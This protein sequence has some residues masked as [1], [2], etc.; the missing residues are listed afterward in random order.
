M[1]VINQVK[2]LNPEVRVAVGGSVEFDNKDSQPHT[3]TS[4]NGSFDT[5]LIAAGAHS[6]VTFEKAGTFAY[7]CSLHPFMKAQIVVA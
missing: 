6:S 2:F 5:G 4:D 3:A 7:H 1:S